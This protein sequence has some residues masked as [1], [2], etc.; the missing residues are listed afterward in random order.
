VNDGFTKG[1]RSARVGHPDKKVREIR[2][3]GFRGAGQFRPGPGG[4]QHESV[5][6]EQRAEHLWINIEACELCAGLKQE[7]C[8]MC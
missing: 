7:S 5:V 4:L 6:R 2:E 8:K 1:D 3:E